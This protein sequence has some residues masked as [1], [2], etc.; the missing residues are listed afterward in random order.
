M[1]KISAMQGTGLDEAFT[2]L[3]NTLQGNWVIKFNYIL[4]IKENLKYWLSGY[5][6]ITD[7]VDILDAKIINVGLTYS[8]LVDPVFVKADVLNNV[9]NQL[10]F[11][12]STKLDI[13]QSFNLLD[14]Y[15]EIR[16]I[17]GVLDVKAPKVKN[18][19]DFGY[20]QIVFDIG[21]NTSSDGNSI[22]CPRNAVFEIKDLNKDIVGV[23]I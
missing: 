17:K 4:K 18:I 12:Y 11:Y 23:A 7:T 2:W 10:L 16:K 20:S 6:M 21:S 8:L 3:V 14:V 1:F 9:K 19:T 15:R 5:K 22:Y 13:G